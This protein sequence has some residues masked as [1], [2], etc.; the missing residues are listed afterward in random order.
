MPSANDILEIRPLANASESEGCARMMA[1]TDPWLTLGRTYDAC[2]Q[3]VSDQ[4]KEVYVARLG[5]AVAGF[6]I[7]NMAGP[8]GAISRR[9]ACIRSAAGEGSAVGSSGGPKS[10]SSVR[11]LMYSCASRRST[12]R[13]SSST[14]G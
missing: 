2:L 9:C 6:V 1:D 14:S 5:G 11:A 13:R 7:I 12:W 8:F 4:S 3:T 10:A